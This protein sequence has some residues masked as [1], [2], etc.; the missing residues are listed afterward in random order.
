MKVLKEHTRSICPNC[1]REIPARI[2]E[3]NGMAYMSKTCR[4][5]GNFIFLLEKDAW[6]YEKLMNKNDLAQ[7]KFSKTMI[8]VTHACNLNCPIC[9]LPDKN[10]PDMSLEAIKKAI[11]SSDVS[12]IRLS[13]GEPTLRKDLAEIIKF[14][15]EQGK[16]PV[17]VTNGIKLADRN[18]VME[19]KKA[20]LQGV[21]F[22]FNG[23]DEEVY[24]RING[25]PLLKI[26]LKALKNLMKEDLNIVFSVLLI[27]GINEKELKKLYRFYLKNVRFLR[28]FRIRTA[29]FTG[30]Y[31]VGQEQI[32]LSDIIEMVSKIIGV[33]KKDLV[34]SAF[35]K[36]FHL[37]CQLTIRPFFL[38]QKI[39][40]KKTDT[41]FLNK[42][43]AI[44][45]LVLEVGIINILFML[46][47]RIKR[48]TPFSNVK[49]GIRVWPD[50]YRIDLNEIKGCPSAQFV[51]STGGHLS[52]CY[53]LTL[54][55]KM[56][57]I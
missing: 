15:C 1:F 18:Y 44:T 5:D 38:L 8:A 23:F 56:L 12:S 37:P 34:E 31:N 11:V 3:E 53:G 14:I 46:I 41:A 50:K 49:I 42:I 57:S 4:E 40:N 39:W 22:C 29:V 16:R 21:A 20:G 24:T 26:K 32:Y 10:Q 30:R 27:K 7:S 33:T 9:Y 52:F 25:Q 36:D 13:G 6:L 17:I 2:Y 48:K 28:E 43:K 54:N 47:S 19:L 45:K 51:N 35:S 55:E